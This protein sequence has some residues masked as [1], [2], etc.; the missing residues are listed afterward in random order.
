MKARLIVNPVSGKDSA[1]DFLQVINERV[2]SCVGDLDIFMTVAS[3]DAMAAAERSVEEGYKFLFVAGGDGTLN[4]VI[5]GVGRANGFAD[6]TFG[7][8]PLGTGND[9][10]DALGLPEDVDRALEI[11]LGGRTVRTDVGKLNE[12]YFINVSAGGFIAEVSDAVNPEL[13][14]VAGKLAYLIG[15]AQVLLDYEPVET[16]IKIAGG[17]GVASGAASVIED[18]ATHER[19]EFSAEVQMFAICNSRLVGGGRMIAPHAVIDDGVFDVCIVR[20]MP[21]LEFIGLLTKVSS[22]DHIEDERV[23]YFRATN[24]E[25]SFAREIK[26]N[27][28]GEVL[29]TNVCRYEIM[30]GAAR[31]LAGD[32]PFAE[33]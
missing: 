4:E 17:E 29:T 10:A 1:P 12:R 30:P 19:K 28:D 13:K 11:L 23:E 14:S 9:F 31:F 33:G 20:G 7:L 27:T 8:V 2:R 18:D 21:S 16:R 5:N 15:G 25:M 22:G 6:I 32:A 3:G 26:V 24:I